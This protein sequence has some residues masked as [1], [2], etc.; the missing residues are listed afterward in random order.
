MNT[1][2]VV[3]TGG[4]PLLQQRALVPLLADCAESAMRIEM[5]TNGTIIPRAEMTNHV[6]RFNVSPKLRNSGVPDDRRIRGNA[7]TT[8]RASGKAI[9]KFVVVKPS[10]LDEVAII[11]EAY[12][13]EPVWIMPEGTDSRAIADRLCVIAD[14]VLSRGWNLSSRLQ[15]LLWDDERG[16]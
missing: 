7:L 14:D 13:L 2:F 4:E 9:F 16:R 3:I 1:S 5:E 10:D 15:T 11:T 8:L 12:G 6:D